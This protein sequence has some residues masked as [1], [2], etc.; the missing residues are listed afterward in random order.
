MKIQKFILFILFMSFNIYAQDSCSELTQDECVL[1]PDCEVNYDA[2]GQFEG[3]E[4]NNTQ[5]EGC[6]EEGEFFCFGCEYFINECDFYECT[7]NGWDGP[8]TLDECGEGDG[9]CDDGGDLLAYLELEDVVGMPGGE[10]VVPMYLTSPIPVGGVQFK[11]LE[12]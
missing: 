2:A 7:E 8:F 10:V 1:A 6:Y 4:E 11:L 9:G 3:C 5:D 12:N